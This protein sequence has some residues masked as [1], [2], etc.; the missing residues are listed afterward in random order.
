[1]VTDIL[2]DDYILE[3]NKI[4]NENSSII[5]YSILQSG[6]NALLQHILLDYQ[7]SYQNLEFFKHLQIDDKIIIVENIFIQEK[8]RRKGL[9]RSFLNKV[10]EIAKEKNVRQIYLIAQIFNNEFYSVDFYEN[11]GFNVIENLSDDKILM[12]FQ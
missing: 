3:K 2:F 11:N 5:E 7:I 12:S 8:E 9:G 10:K 1:M 6:H 4:I